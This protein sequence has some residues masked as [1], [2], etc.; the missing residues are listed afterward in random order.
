MKN[1]MKSYL[2]VLQLS[3]LGQRFLMPQHQEQVGTNVN[4][5]SIKMKRESEDKL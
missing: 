5:I 3:F 2:D 4:Y 1:N